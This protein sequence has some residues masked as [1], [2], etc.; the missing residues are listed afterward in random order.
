MTEGGKN[1]IK[2]YNIKVLFILILFV[3][4]IGL[5]I[6]NIVYSASES[7]NINV[8]MTVPSDVPPVPPSG[9]GNTDSIP[10]EISGVGVNPGFTTSTISWT[11]I[12]NDIVTVC[13]FDYGLTE[14]YGMTAVPAVAVD[15]QS[16]TVDLTELSTSTLYFYKITCFDA[17]ANSAVYTDFFNT[18][19]DG[20][21]G[22]LTI[23]ARPEK[24]V[25]KIGGNLFLNGILLIIHPVSK[26]VIFTKNIS[27][28]NVGTSTINDLSIPIGNFEAVFKGE[29]HLAKRIINVN[30]D[31]SFDNLLDFTNTDSYNLLAGDV[32]GEGLKDNFID[33][34]DIS[35]ID[36]NFNSNLPI[37]D[38]NR[39]GIVDVLDMSMVIVNYNKAGDAI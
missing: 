23:K 33:I 18:L 25:Q 17:S 21:I 26:N 6:G 32:Q 8:Q 22:Q 11:A 39:D 38:L 2:L 19:T 35:A 3:V 1:I 7:G 37:F 30:I 16:Y 5:V 12:D 20:F 13:Y 9:G 34:L 4:G 27:L 31:N 15:G 28:N 14:L 29:S 10:P 36:I 24:R